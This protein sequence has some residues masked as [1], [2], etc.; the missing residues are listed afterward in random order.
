MLWCQRG[1]RVNLKIR[2]CGEL[3]SWRVGE[4]EKWRVRDVEV[5]AICVP[6]MMFGGITL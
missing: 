2:R 6:F 5:F 3:E 1:S 4:L